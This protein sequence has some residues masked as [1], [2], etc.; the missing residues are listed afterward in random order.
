[1]S[2]PAHSAYSTGTGG[3]NY[4]SNA[5]YSSTWAGGPGQYNYRPPMPQSNTDRY[6]SWYNSYGGARG[7]PPPPGMEYN[8]N[9]GHHFLNQP[10]PPPPAPIKRPAFKL[11]RSIQP[12][13]MLSIL[14]ELAGSEKPIFDYYDVPMVE[15]ERRAW[16][17]DVPVEEVGEFE[18]K[19][20]IGDLEFIAEGQTKPEARVA[21]AEVTVQGL[22]AHKCELNDIEGVGASEDNCPWAAIAS[23]ALHRLYMD[24]QSQG[25]TIPEELIN[26]PDSG[27]VFSSHGIGFNRAP[28]QPVELDK[29]PLQ[30]LNEMAAKMK[31]TPEFELTGEEGTPNEK[32]FTMTVKIGDQTYTGEG[33]NKKAAR[34]AAA[35]VALEGRDSWYI[36]GGLVEQS[37]HQGMGGGEGAAEGGAE[38]GA[39][40]VPPPEKRINLDMM[41]AVGAGLGDKGML[42]GSYPGNVTV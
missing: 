7:Q 18:C 6:N 10:A 21:V 30:K 35:S 8:M 26:L 2:Y 31:K 9:R 14:H 27:P 25:Y 33:K 19:C 20:I 39:E 34:H 17:S 38:G 23:L 4:G 32:V 3:S 11:R 28:S 1:M 41:E 13:P 22:I 29:N 5:G 15:R 24:W 36:E 12:R 37:Q 16:Q 40:G 42:P